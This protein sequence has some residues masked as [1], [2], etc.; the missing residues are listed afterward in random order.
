MGNDGTPQEFRPTLLAL[1]VDQR[2]LTKFVSAVGAGMYERA[3]SS[4]APL[5]DSQAVLWVAG[6]LFFGV[7]DLLTTVV[8][9]QVGGVTERNVVPALLIG[10]YGLA[11]MIGLK[12]FAFG[13]CYAL[14]RV[15]GRPHRLGVPLGLALL[16]VVVTFWN[17]RV[18]LAV[19]LP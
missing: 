2:I 1:P 11:G 18:L 4:A 7:G 8:G 17:L 15:V 9:L 14:W 19:M 16:G 6:V 13:G 5:G 10:Q 3:A 12:L